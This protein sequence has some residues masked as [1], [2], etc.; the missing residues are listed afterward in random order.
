M[1]SSTKDK[2]VSKMEPVADK[3]GGGSDIT[4]KEKTKSSSDKMQAKESNL[5]KPS[6]K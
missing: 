1:D 5:K 2:A 6:G 4:S 3:V